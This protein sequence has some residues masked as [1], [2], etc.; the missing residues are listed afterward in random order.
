M[1]I[2]AIMEAD[3]QSQGGG[4]PE[5]IAV[6]MAGFK[7]PTTNYFK[8]ALPNILP[9]ATQD[10]QQAIQR[11]FARDAVYL[12]PSDPQKVLK[13]YAHQIA[14]RIPR[15]CPEGYKLRGTTK[16]WEEEKIVEAAP[17]K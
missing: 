7:L 14:R 9:R 15:T 6:Q 11:F 2:M 16:I 17:K 12:D 13:Q 1:G 10:A 5:V 8:D 3:L 4:G